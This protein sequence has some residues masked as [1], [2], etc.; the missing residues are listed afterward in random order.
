M[1]LTMV[2]FLWFG[3]LQSSEANDNRPDLM[4]VTAHGGAI[5][6]R[7]SGEIQAWLHQQNVWKPS[8][9]QSARALATCRQN[10]GCIQSILQRRGI[11][12]AIAISI[13]GRNRRARVTL[14]QFHGG[15][16]E[17][18]VE[19][20][21]MDVRV[22]L[23]QII[24]GLMASQSDQQRAN[25]G[26]RTKHDSVEGDWRRSLAVQIAM[27]E[28]IRIVSRVEALFGKFRYHDA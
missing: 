16:L 9:D 28:Q 24:V 4:P 3:G 5:D 19:G 13:R 10:P 7:L 1:W 15:K 2:L 21:W 6:W 12:S 23:D 18:S 11:T 22:T 27:A 20:R 25:L 8:P 14:H 17:R 26:N